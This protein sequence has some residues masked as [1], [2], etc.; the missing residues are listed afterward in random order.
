MRIS[1]R[2][3]ARAG[4]LALCI[5][6][7]SP[8]VQAADLYFKAEYGISSG[9][10]TTDGADP[11]G[12]VGEDSDDASPVVGTALGLA[13]PLYELFPWSMRLPKVHIPIWPGKALTMG[14]DEDWS[15]PDWDM[16]FE[17][18]YGGLREYEFKTDAV[19]DY[20]TSAKAHS[21]MLSTRLDIPIQAPINALFGRL[22]I[23]DPLTLHGGGGAGIALTDVATAVNNSRARADG[24][25]FAYQAEVGLGYALS[26]SLHLSL[27]WR[28]LNM[29]VSEADLISSVGIQV[30]NFDVEMAAHEFTTGLEYRFWRIPLFEDRD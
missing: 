1:K 28:Y 21:F 17:L 20:F 19:D 2:S 6:L 5:L 14:G 23:L 8:T 11:L 16:R 29:G 13:V 18:A 7:T 9:I 22:P 25:N 12:S 27:G 26:E 4:L 3:L 10:G 30:G 15:F 24:I